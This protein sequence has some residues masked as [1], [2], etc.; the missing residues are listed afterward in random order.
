MMLFNEEKSPGLCRSFVFERVTGIRSKIIPQ[1]VQYN[2]F[3]DAK[4][5]RTVSFDAVC[6]KENGELSINRLFQVT[7]YRDYVKKCQEQITAKEMQV[8]LIGYLFS[9]MADKNYK[10]NDPLIYRIVDSIVNF[11]RVN[12]I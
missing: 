7:A 6:S 12:L 8:L 1:G 10:I 11:L 4:T 2:I 9:N 3:F 5:T